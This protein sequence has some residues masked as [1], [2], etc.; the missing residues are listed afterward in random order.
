MGVTDMTN[1]TVEQLTNHK[2]M[3]HGFVI[4]NGRALP[5]QGMGGMKANEII[6]RCKA[7]AIAEAA[8]PVDEIAGT[9]ATHVIVDE[10]ER[11]PFGMIFDPYSEDRS[12][13]TYYGTEPPHWHEQNPWKDRVLY[14]PL[15][16]LAECHAAIGKPYAYLDE[17]PLIYTV[18]MCLDHWREYGDKLDA[19]VLTGKTFTAGVRFGPDGP[20]Y[21]SPGFSLPKLWKL[22]QKYGNQERRSA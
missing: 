11:A 2:L 6:E 4:S 22:V 12:I 13:Q 20:D 19:Y 8:A 10:L 1:I 9:R 15:A 14:I 21:L 7:E 5:P 17:Q 16:E 18:A 3:K